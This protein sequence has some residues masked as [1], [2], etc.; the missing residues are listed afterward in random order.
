MSRRCDL[1]TTVIV[2]T[3]VA[4]VYTLSYLMAQFR[5][6][7]DSGVR[8]YFEFARY[9]IYLLILLFLASGTVVRLGQLVF[10]AIGWSLW[11]SAAVASAYLV[12]IPGV[13][14]LLRDVVYRES[15]TNIDPAASRYRL[16][17]P[18]ENPNFLAF[19][20]VVVLSYLL[21]F[22]TGKRRSVLVVLDAGLIILTGS[23]SGLVA[24]IVVFILFGLRAL[25]GL[26]SSRDQKS[27]IFLAVVAAIAVLALTS[28][29]SDVWNSPRLAG[30]VEALREGR[31]LDDRSVEGRLTSNREAMDQFLASPFIGSGAQKYAGFDSVDNQFLKILLRGGLLAMVPLAVFYSSAFRAQEL[32]AR[33]RRNALGIISLWASSFV[34][35]MAGAFL[36]SFRLFF[37]FWTFVLLI[38]SLNRD[39]DVGPRPGRR[40]TKLRAG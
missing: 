6:P 7:F 27:L 11:F 3:V 38:W 13:S 39:V 12:A 29:A 19:Y 30:T 36:E 23:R 16:S 21:F 40:S 32:A 4:F 33:R 1:T 24:G 8:D 37:L 26:M 31:I 10:K 9:P 5:D 22:Q 35:L 18:F 15:K 17:A 28:V 20:L 34:M 25:R 14:D 2:F